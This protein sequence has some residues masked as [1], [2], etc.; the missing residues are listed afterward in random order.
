[1]I[2]TLNLT[3]QICHVEAVLTH[4][5]YD[6]RNWMRNLTVRDAPAIVWGPFDHPTTV[7]PLR[8]ER[9]YDVALASLTK[10]GW[11]G[12]AE[13]AHPKHELLGLVMRAV[14]DYEQVHHVFP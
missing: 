3:T 14:L 13:S 1:M 11:Q 9:D 4:A 10:L 2:V 7:R 12:A 5:D 6:R 8:D